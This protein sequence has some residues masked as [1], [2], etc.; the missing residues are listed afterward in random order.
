MLN[1]SGGLRL[2]A[3]WQRPPAL[4]PPPTSHHHHRHHHLP[5][6]PPPAGKYLFIRPECNAQMSDAGLVVRVTRGGDGPELLTPEEKEQLCHHPAA[7]ELLQY[8]LVKDP[9][10]RPSVGDLARRV[11]ARLAAL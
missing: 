1:F 9:T 11:E 3:S 10:R 8:T 2:P 6:T 4:I 5:A 7:I